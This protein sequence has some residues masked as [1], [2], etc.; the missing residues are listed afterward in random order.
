MLDTSLSL[1]TP[2]VAYLP[3]A[4]VGGSGFFAVAVARLWLGYRSPSVQ[5]AE[6]RIAERINWRTVS[7]LLENAVFLLIG[8]QLPAI[9]RAA[10][11]T[12]IGLGPG[13]LMG[14][15]IYAAMVVARF[16]WVFAATAVYRYGPGRVRER[17]WSWRTALAISYAGVRGVVTLAGGFLL[18]PT[19]PVGFLQLVAFVVVV[20][21]LLQ[22]LG[23]GALV[24]SLHLPLPNRDQDR[25]QVRTLLAEAQSSA[26]DRLEVERSQD[27]S[28]VLLS[29]LRQS[30][31]YRIALG[32]TEERGEVAMPDR[33][34]RLRL[35]MLQSEREAVLAARQEGRYEE[36]VVDTVL[37]D[38]D[39]IETAMKRSVRRD[40]PVRPVVGHPLRRLLPARPNREHV[41]GRR[42][43]PS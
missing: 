27:D 25:M 3:A 42:D 32:T 40:L 20:L 37:A 41:G 21:S 2:Y 43:E 4:A 30:A 34:A 17:R 16:V 6:A 26:L 8:L 19:A 23:L 39:S 38:L 1:V 28:A 11:R 29:S 36:V 31:E 10:T 22:G 15:A 35:L 9:V 12:G 7:F 33:W 5:S 24:R 14:A 18:P 13:V